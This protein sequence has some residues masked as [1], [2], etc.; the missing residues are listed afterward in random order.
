[1]AGLA[2]VLV[3]IAYLLEWVT[4][5]KKLSRRK[6]QKLICET[7]GRF[8]ANLETAGQLPMQSKKVPEFQ[9]NT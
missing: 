3:G 8:A 5:K 6:R 1:M 9:L 7:A 4:K 2:V